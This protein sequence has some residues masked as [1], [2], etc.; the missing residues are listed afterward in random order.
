MR[1]LLLIFLFLTPGWVAAQN[2]A[3]DQV[4][5]TA[6]LAQDS[7][8]IGQPVI[9]RIKVLV[10]T[11]MPSP[12]VFP[13]MERENLL[14]RLPE[15]ASGPVSDDVNGETWS[16]VQR[17]YRLYPL[18]S[19]QVDFGAQEVIVTFADP[20]TNDPVEVTASLPALTLTATI[21]DGARGLDPLI[22]ATGFALEQHIEGEP[23]LDAGGAITR[24]LVADIAGTTPIMIPD[25]LPDFQ[26]PLLRA[27]PKEPRFSETED[28]GILSGQRTDEAAYV[29]QAGGHTQLPTVSVDWYNLTSQQVETASVD[30][31]QL[32]LAPPP[33]KPPSA[34]VIVKALLWIVALCLLGW[35]LWRVLGPRLRD[36]RRE[37]RA[38]HVASATF[39]LNQLKSALRARDLTRSY[40]ALELWK[41]R[42]TDPTGAESLEQCL[43]RIGAHRYAQRATPASEDWSAAL[44]AVG[45]LRNQRGHGAQDLPPLNP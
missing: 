44:S 7:V 22:I 34:D 4:Q 20:E 45:N 27:Y 9:L 29:A 40:A 18:A 30:A 17:S 14:V 23:D 3:S 11:F 2:A 16:G 19:G 36:L 26:D 41:S 28:R 39:A 10:P 25:L 6:E 15:R 42:S 37:R 21:P 12:P 8:V 38:R 13:S 24:R 33:R 32:T 43:I 35:G 5:V 1:V 31:V